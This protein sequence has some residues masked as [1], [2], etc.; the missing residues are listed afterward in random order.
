MFPQINIKETGI[1]LRLIMDKRGITP[2]KVKEYLKLGSVQSVYDVYLYYETGDVLHRY[3]YKTN[4]YE[5][6]GFEW[7]SL[8][9]PQ[10]LNVVDVKFEKRH[11]HY[12][13]EKRA[14]IVPADYLALDYGDEDEEK[15]EV[16]RP[17]V[18]YMAFVKCKEKQIHYMV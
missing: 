8:Y 5:E 1:N 4:L 15:M 13:L 2:R 17:D 16:E 11:L 14:L 7:I 12:D 6:R 18:T 9:S 3:N 10:G